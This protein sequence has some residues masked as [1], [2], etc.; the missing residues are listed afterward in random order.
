M[1]TLNLICALLL[2]SLLTLGLFASSVKSFFTVDELT[3][4]GVRVEPSDAHEQSICIVC[5]S[6]ASG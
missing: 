6:Q 5:T 3:E 4:M 1:N 2:T